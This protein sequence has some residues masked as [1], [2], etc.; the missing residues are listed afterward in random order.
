[1][2]RKEKGMTPNEFGMLKIMARVALVLFVLVFLWLG[3]DVHRHPER[4][5][6]LDMLDVSIS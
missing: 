6:E 4:N 2:L 3:Y 5:K 1:M